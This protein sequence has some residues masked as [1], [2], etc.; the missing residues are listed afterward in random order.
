MV[1]MSEFSD[2]VSGGTMRE[3]HP[4]A[5]REVLHIPAQVPH[6][7]RV[8]EGGHINLCARAKPG[9]EGSN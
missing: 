4:V 8:P 5:V 3:P 7:Y 9:V 2:S 1:L 6:A